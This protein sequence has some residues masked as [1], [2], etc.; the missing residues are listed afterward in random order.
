LFQDCAKAK[1]A[2]KSD[3]VPSEGQICKAFVTFVS[4]KGCFLRLANHIT[5]RVML[6]DLADSFLDNPAESFP[7]GKLVE[8]RVQS[9]DHLRGTVQLNLKPSVVVGNLQ[10]QKEI[11]HIHDGDFVTGTVERVNEIGVFVRIKGTSL[12][13][14]S[15]KA[16][17]LDDTSRALDEV[18]TVGDVVKAR[19][20][21]VSDTTMKIALGLA[22]TYFRG[23]EEVNNNEDDVDNNVDEDEVDVEDEG[24]DDG[25]VDKENGEDDESEEVSLVME[26]DSNDEGEA[27]NAVAAQP[28][29]TSLVARKRK[30]IDS[31]ND[32]A[33]PVH[34]HKKRLAEQH[35]DDE[36]ELGELQW[37]IGQGTSAPKT[38]VMNSDSDSDADNDEGDNDKSSK[39]RT[40]QKEAERK[41]SEKELRSREV[42]T[43]WSV[44]IHVELLLTV[45]CRFT[46]TA[47]YC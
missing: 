39:L 4:D 6:R 20:L 18:F 3:I 46:L 34:S 2:I 37:N 42:G 1:D 43:D 41:R 14:L 30:Q 22:S 11:K 33:F 21:R 15:R 47:R 40:R 7:V 19:V 29:K 38:V 16:T 8:G 31:D 28:A 12:V 13:G 25:E 9:V 23:T 26:V 24:E 45:C 35:E 32:E 44:L 27:I 10:S 36:D 17:S 5:G